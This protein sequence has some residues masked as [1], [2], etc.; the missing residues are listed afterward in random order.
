M[1]GRVFFSWEVFEAKI[2]LPETCFGPMNLIPM[3]D[4]RLLRSFGEPYA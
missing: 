2:R 4:T 3:P 1:Q